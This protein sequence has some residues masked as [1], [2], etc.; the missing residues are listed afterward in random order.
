MTTK[1]HSQNIFKLNGVDPEQQGRISPVWSNQRG[2]EINRAELNIYFQTL[3][4]ENQKLSDQRIRDEEISPLIRL[5]F[6]HPTYLRPLSTKYQANDTILDYLSLHKYF[7]GQRQSRGLANLILLIIIIFQDWPYPAV[8]VAVLVSQW[9]STSPPLATTASCRHC[10]PGDTGTPWR[11]WWSVEDMA[12]TSGHP[13]SLWL[14]GAG[15]EQ[16]HC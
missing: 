16:L 4:W 8:T 9:R 1:M 6:Y 14:T 3:R 2:R 11:S 7:R 12:V 5:I 15:R 13:A 10:R